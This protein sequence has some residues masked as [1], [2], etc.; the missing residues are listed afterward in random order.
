[1]RDPEGQFKRNYNRCSFAFSH[2][3]RGNPLFD[4][5]HLIDYSRLLPDK[6][7]LAYWSNGT[8]SV[9]DRWETPDGPRPSLQDTIAHIA[10]N[11]SLVLLKRIEL[12]ATFGPF[13]RE[14]MR[15]VTDLVGSV[16]RDDV[17]IGRG[18]LLIAS[19][20]RITSYHIDADTNFLFQIT[21]DKL[22]SVFNQA[23]RM[24]ISD[25]ELES[26]YAGDLNGASFKQSR[27]QDGKTYELKPGLG[28]H[29]PSMA[30]HWAQNGDNVSIALSVNFDLRSIERLAR[31]Y[32]LNHRLRRYGFKPTPPGVSLWRDR[33][34]LA[35]AYG[36]AATRGLL[37]R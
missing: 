25:R 7:Q 33:V 12:D 20:R 22:I 31:I 21:G 23:D 14:L 5:Q 34:K 24:L 18:T 11:N 28:I 3:L 10:E 35:G 16:M 17:I 13:M 30:P 9:T 37:R 6:P 2:E 4:L 27:E 32:K 19:P 1:V 29:I 26:Y 36:L 15:Q 8:V